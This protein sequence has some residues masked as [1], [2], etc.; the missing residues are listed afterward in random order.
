[1]SDG[2]DDRTGPTG[3]VRVTSP[4]T[5]ASTHVRRSVRQE[6]DES[7]GVGEIY[8]RSL[9][10]SQLRAAITVAVT[11]L[12]SIGALP[13]VFLTFDAVT[14]A[15]VLGVPLPWIVLGVL[16]YPFLFTIGWLYIRQAER[17][18]R[19]FAALVEPG[20]DDP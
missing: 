8:M 5:T 7:T 1:M 17:A 14:D 16:V 4:L 9:I 2:P 15:T 12:L 13:L 10:R 3:R 6:I 11:L 18:E 19:D 20:S